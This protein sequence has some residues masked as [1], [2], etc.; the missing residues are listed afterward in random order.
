MQNGLMTFVMLA[1]PTNWQRQPVQSPHTPDDAALGVLCKGLDE[2]GFACI[3][4]LF[5]PD[6]YL[7]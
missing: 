3:A 7:N 5:G 1:H 4:S 6:S 2:A